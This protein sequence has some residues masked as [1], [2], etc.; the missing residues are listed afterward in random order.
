[1]PNRDETFE[2]FDTGR[3]RWDHQADAEAPPLDLGDQSGGPGATDDARAPASVPAWQRW[4]ILAAVFVFGVVAGAYVWHGRGPDVSVIAGPI[5]WSDG[6][7]SDPATDLFEVEV[8]NAGE[9]DLVVTRVEVAGWA[10]WSEEWPDREFT[11]EPGTWRRFLVRTE[12][13]C[14]LPPPDEVRLA[15]MTASGTREVTASTPD[16]PAF[17]TYMQ[18]CA[19]KVQDQ[20]IFAWTSRAWTDGVT[21]SHQSEIHLST[22][23]RAGVEVTGA[24]VS[25][26]GLRAETV[27]FVSPMVVTSTRSESIMLE[28]HITD[29]T[30][31]AE[32]DDIALT[33]EVLLSSGPR[34]ETIELDQG[35]LFAVA[36]YAA[37]ECGS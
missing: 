6:L 16:S 7:G 10:D 31:A 15:V 28:W 33:V 11:V 25:A 29:C 2:V 35:V 30:A 1:V 27:R 34:T 18:E 37:Q 36:R 12:I 8:F 17:Q 4:A 21:G 19:G 24:S 23:L 22:W 9:D 14:E 5:E 20:T 13:T 32:I 3:Q 26:P